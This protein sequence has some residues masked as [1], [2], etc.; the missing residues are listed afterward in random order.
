MAVESRKITGIDK[1]NSKAIIMN[2]VSSR[3]VKDRYYNKRNEKTKATI[4]FANE[5]MANVDYMPG[6]KKPSS[7]T[8][9]IEL[10]ELSSYIVHAAESY[11]VGRNSIDPHEYEP[12]T[13][14]YI[15]I[16][17]N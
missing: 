12:F 3:D 15:P 17:I 16:E 9:V 5:I 11:E 14:D 8:I 4:A 13:F 6:C 7:S 2:M 1:I 10:N